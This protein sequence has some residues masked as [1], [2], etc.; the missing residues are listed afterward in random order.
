MK[1]KSGLIDFLDGNEGARVSRRCALEANQRGDFFWVRDETRAVVGALPSAARRSYF[2]P[3][4]GE[5]LRR[6]AGPHSTT[7]RPP[8]ASVSTRSR[9]T[10]LRLETTRQHSS[11]ALARAQRV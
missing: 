7:E 11:L 10:S 8:T 3:T 5:C 1:Q 9:S 2:P 4:R 6:A